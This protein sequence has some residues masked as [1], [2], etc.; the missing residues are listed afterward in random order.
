MPTVYGDIQ[1]GNCYKI[2]LLFSNLNVAHQW[3]EVLV[4]HGET[5]TDEFLKLNP[6]AQIPVVQLDDGTVL[7]QSNA[8]LQHFARNSALLPEEPLLQTR[9]LEWQFFEQYNHEPTIAV[10]RFI[11]KFQSMPA[12][13]RDEYDRLGPRGYAALDVMEKHL[14]QSDF[15]VGDAYS[16]ADISLYAYTHVADEGGFDLSQYGG[17]T[18]WLSRVEQQHGFVSM[19]GYR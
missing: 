3:R 1:S 4:T 9:V 10:R 11:Q 16:I 18:N 2:A 7:T 12:E 19:A 5:R 17:I 14:Q 6:A 15:L 8:I 13:R